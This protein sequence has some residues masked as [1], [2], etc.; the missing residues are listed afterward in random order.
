MPSDV[1]ILMSIL[2]CCR[3]VITSCFEIGCSTRGLE[4]WKEAVIKFLG[5][6][7][8]NICSMHEIFYPQIFCK[9]F[10]TKIPMVMVAI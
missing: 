4:E 7:V 9:M 2:K 10:T 6:H 5:C 1:A 8:I 3:P